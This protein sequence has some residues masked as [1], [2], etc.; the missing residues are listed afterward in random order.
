MSNNHN[1]SLPESI[2]KIVNERDQIWDTYDK[3]KSNSREV[4]TLAKDIVASNATPVNGNLA[5]GTPPAEISKARNIVAADVETMKQA[6]STIRSN[7]AEIERLSKPCAS[8]S[9][10]LL[11][12]FNAGLGLL[13]LAEHLMV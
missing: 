13:A 10:I 5:D 9:G 7:T 11:L 6:Y 1:L 4:D 12:L 8:A 2:M 3:A